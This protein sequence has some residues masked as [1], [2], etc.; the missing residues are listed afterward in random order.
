MKGPPRRYKS[1]A[2]SSFF[3][4]FL[5]LF[6]LFSFFLFDS[7]RK[8]RLFDQIDRSLIDLCRGKII[9]YGVILAERMR[10][11]ASR[12]TLLLSP[13]MRAGKRSSKLWDQTLGTCTALI[14]LP[15]KRVQSASHILENC[16]GH[17]TS[18]QDTF[19]RIGAT[20]HPLRL[21]YPRFSPFVPIFHRVFHIQLAGRRG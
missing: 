10:R 20:R 8:H 21:S 3:L 12:T 16:W 14:L 6:S 19:P 13:S 1:D 15:R 17:L 7:S 5:L 11:S 18:W 4:F 9:N 2:A